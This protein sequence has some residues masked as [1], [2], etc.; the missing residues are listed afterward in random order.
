MSA[1]DDA[2]EACRA[3]RAHLLDG[4]YLRA[5]FAL[6]DLQMALV[7]LQTPAAPPVTEEEAPV[8]HEVVIGDADCDVTVTVPD[9]LNGPVPRDDV[10][11]A[12]MHLGRE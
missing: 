1:V 4:E 5:A 8:M 12:G 10:Q 6:G 3:L 9:E 11:T 7:A 2:M